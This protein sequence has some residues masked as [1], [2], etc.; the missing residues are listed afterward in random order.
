MVNTVF[1][2]YCCSG[3]RLTLGDKVAVYRF[4]DSRLFSHKSSQFFIRWVMSQPIFFSRLLPDFVSS[5]NKL[6]LLK[7]YHHAP[8]ENATLCT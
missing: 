1:G 4:S 5:Y 8:W 2:E 6:F 3:S 7:R